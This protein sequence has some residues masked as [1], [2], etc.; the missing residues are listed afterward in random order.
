MLKGENSESQNITAFLENTVSKGA[1]AKNT[2]SLHFIDKEFK[3]TTGSCDGLAAVQDSASGLWG[4]ID[5]TG[6]Y[7]IAPEYYGAYSFSEGLAAVNI[8]GKWGFI[9]TQGNVVLEPVYQALRTER[10][11]NGYIRVFGPDGEN[12]NMIEYEMDHNGQKKAEVVD[13]ISSDTRNIGI[14]PNNIDV[15]YHII[16]DENGNFCVMDEDGK[17]IVRL[18][19]LRGGTFTD[20][21][22]S[23]LTPNYMVIYRII[24]GIKQEALIDYQGNTVIDFKYD[25]LRPFRGDTYL[26]A[27]DAD[28]SSHLIDTNG[29]I[30]RDIDIAVCPENYCAYYSDNISAYGKVIQPE[31]YSGYCYN[32]IDLFNNKTGEIFHTIDLSSASMTE[33]QLATNFIF[34]E[35]CYVTWNSSSSQYHSKLCRVYDYEGNLLED[36]SDEAQHLLTKYPPFID[37]RNNYT[38]LLLPVLKE[39]KIT[40]LVIE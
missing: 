13:E 10:F 25:E 31:G 3:D 16:A 15:S 4:F 40:F 5:K 26:L 22:I 24:N 19:D 38:Q 12:G 33:R 17:L 1:S 9:D 32:S 39:N 18:S 6:E 2:A 11:E 35:N 30:I 27:H 8:D 20:C 29:N 23:Y 21:Y 14:L 28:D 34:L 37:L 36:I 7:V